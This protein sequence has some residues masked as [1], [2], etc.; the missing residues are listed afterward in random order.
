MRTKN[1]LFPVGLLIGAAWILFNPLVTLIDLI[2]DV[3]AYALIL[4]TL[5]HISTFVPYI[6]EA[7]D[8]FRKLFFISL[9][10][11]PALVIMLVM[12]S[13][14]ITVTLFT[15]SFAVLEIIFLLP[16]FS[17]LFEGLY[18]LGQ[19]FGCT[20]AIQCPRSTRRVESVRTVTF[21]FLIVRAALSTLPDFAFLLEYDSLTGEG[22][23]VTNTQYAFLL[24]IAFVLSLIMGI[25]WLSRILPY[26]H[27]LAED[28]GV[29]ALTPPHDEAML[30]RE[31]K[32]FRISLPYILFSLAAI[33]S[34][35]FV[36]DNASV[37]PD[38]LCATVFLVLSIL[39]YY[40]EKKQNPLIPFVAL[41]HLASTVIFEIY[42]N[43]FFARFSTS[44][45]TRLPEA[46]AAYLPVILSSVAKELLFLAIFFLL[47]L[48]I[49]R[50]YRQYDI[51]E[52]PKNV[53]EERLL[54]EYRR[55]TK[56]QNGLCAAFATA[57]AIL[58]FLDIVLARFST[59]VDMHPGFGGGA[60]YLPIA[61][62]LWIAVLVLNI[63]LAVTVSVLSYRRAGEIFTMQELDMPDSV[64][65]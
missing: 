47:G 56:W 9:F 46:D 38:Y 41:I 53:C 18:Y 42:R 37:L 65:G 25:V 12:A 35:D 57:T 6:K 48:A 26:L 40:H 33:L 62:S 36:A 13:Q 59:K 49:C 58:A 60:Y 16:A 31:S 45:L 54:L 28:E 19:R 52:E 44:D 1:K 17:H 43:Q 8:G 61:A 39:L 32:R 29:H 11:I 23:T 3:I 2:P 30:E 21:I 5:R 22:I 14:R 24:A 27:G 15:L 55:A 34:I 51:P 50:F 7:V 63:A 64:N 20:A 10:K 4:F